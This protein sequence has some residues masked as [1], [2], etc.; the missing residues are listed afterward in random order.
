MFNPEPFE[1]YRK[2]KKWN[3]KVMAEFLCMPYG[4]YRYLCLGKLKNLE[5]AK[6]YAD[7]IGVSVKTLII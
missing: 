2:E 4:S 3:K 1:K 7:K 6:R 5:Y